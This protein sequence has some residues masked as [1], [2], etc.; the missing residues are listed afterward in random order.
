ME[1]GRVVGLG[2][3]FVGFERG[4]RAGGVGQR[5]VCVWL[6]HYGGRDRGEQHCQM[7]RERV[8]RLGVGFEPASPCVGG[9]DQQPVCGWL[10]HRGWRESLILY[11]H[12]P[13]NATGLLG[14]RE[15]RL[16]YGDQLEYGHTARTQR[17]RDYRCCRSGDSHP[18]LRN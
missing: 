14:W 16:E 3:G 13:Y 2:I 5:P 8:V 6:F 7:E 15:W 18:L 1:R 17:R 12:C 4:Q 9:G 11:G 10:F